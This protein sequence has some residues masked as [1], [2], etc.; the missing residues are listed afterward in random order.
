MKFTDFSL[1]KTSVSHNVSSLNSTGLFRD[2]GP[3]HQY[4]AMAIIMVALVSVSCAHNFPIPSWRSTISSGGEASEPSS[5]P[6]RQLTSLSTPASEPEATEPVSNRLA[7]DPA[8]PK[9]PISN[10]EAQASISEVSRDT[11]E[12]SPSS[13]SSAVPLAS[14]VEEEEGSVV[15]SEGYVCVPEKS[16]AADGLAALLE[17]GISEDLSEALPEDSKNSEIAPIEVADHPDVEKWKRYFLS[18]HATFQRYLDRGANYQK[19]VSHVLEEEGLPAELFYLALIESGFS[20]SARSV[21]RAVGIWQFI[22]GTGKRYGLKINYYIDERRDPVRATRAAARYLASLY[23]VYQSWELA[24][25][26]YN[27]GE[28]RVLSA[29]MRG[30]TRDFWELSSQKLLPR[31]TRNYVPKIMAAIHLGSHLEKYGF[32]F[33]VTNNYGIPVAAKVPGGVSLKHVA[34]AAR[35][36][37][38]SLKTLNP[39]LRRSMTPPGESYKVWVAQPSQVSL[40]AGSY[41]SL[42]SRRQR[43]AARSSAPEGYH[44]VRRGQNLGVISRRYGLTVNQLKSLNGLRGTRIYV[45]QKLK[46]SSVGSSGGQ[47]HVVKKGD[48]LYS[49][50]KR[51]NTS[52]RSLKRKNRIATRYLQIGQKIRL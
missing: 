42:R 35:V 32:K 17:Q 39:H 26:A 29:I 41:R 6:A 30:H 22:P 16:A 36:S 8:E 40:I 37:V 34:S 24:A 2:H 20:T 10:I 31:E 49:I 11:S 23:R 14:A 51:Y 48:T 3:R 12:S 5:E 4:L 45:G 13:V 50:A 28:R 38:A 43:V 47:V 7:K 44:L 46:V 25:S 33:E 1:I 19:L 21:A 18:E 9:A 52:V 15:V 27:A